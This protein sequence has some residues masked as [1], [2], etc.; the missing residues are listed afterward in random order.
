MLIC[1]VRRLTGLLI[2]LDVDGSQA[3]FLVDLF[4]WRG[5]IFSFELS[6]GVESRIPDFAESKLLCGGFIIQL[7]Q[8]IS[9][10]S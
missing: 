7:G 8:S 6:S 2:C 1:F 9:D 4:F 5:K 3:H 10:K